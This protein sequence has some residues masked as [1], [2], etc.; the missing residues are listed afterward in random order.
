MVKHCC[1]FVTLC[2]SFTLSTSWFLSCKNGIGMAV[3][4]NV[5]EE[6]LMRGCVCYYKYYIASYLIL[7]PICPVVISQYKFRGNEARPPCWHQASIQEN[8]ILWYK[9]Y[10]W[11]L[12]KP[13]AATL[14]PQYLQRTTLQNQRPEALA[15]RY[16]WIFFLFGVWDIFI[17]NQSYK[18]LV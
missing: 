2:K 4:Q 15:W 16:C 10:S 7:N 5:G 6:V 11:E 18:M 13:H 1:T 3:L 12:Q 9:I 17:F 14:N 8:M